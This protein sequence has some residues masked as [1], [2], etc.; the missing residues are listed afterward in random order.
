MG[1]R[2]AEAGSQGLPCGDALEPRGSPGALV[3]QPWPTCGSGGGAVAE[4]SLKA[5]FNLNNRQKTLKGIP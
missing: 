2:H 3:I 5:Q 4:R 1:G